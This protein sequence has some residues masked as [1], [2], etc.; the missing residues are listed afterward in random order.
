MNHITQSER[1]NYVKDTHNPN[2]YKMFEF[3]SQFPGCSPLRIQMWDHDELFGDDF[4]GETVI[5]LEDRFFS[6][7]WQ[8]INNK[9]IELRQIYHKSTKVSQGVI[10]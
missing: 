3:H 10:K 1:D 5:D 2:I 8:S 4:I 6:P 9:P 7:E